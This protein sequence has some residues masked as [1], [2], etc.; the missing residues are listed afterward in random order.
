M[1]KT[2]ATQAR[3]KHPINESAVEGGVI[4]G[5]FNASRRS[6]ILTI[7]SF[8]DYTELNE[9]SFGAKCPAQFSNGIAQDSLHIYR[10]AHLG[11]NLVDLLFAC[12][13]ITGFHDKAGI[14]HKQGQTF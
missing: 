8:G 10:A 14:F 13:Q 12:G 6:I 5:S 4:T 11:S 2:I 3:E 1:L 7:I 9:S